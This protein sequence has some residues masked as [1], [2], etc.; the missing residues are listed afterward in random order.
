MKKLVFCVLTLACLSALATGLRADD[1]AIVANVD[2]D[3][4]AA[5]KTFPAGTYRFAPDSPGSGFVTIRNQE[6]DSTAVVLP[7]VYDSSAPKRAHLLLRR[8]D[9]VNYLSEIAT[10][11][12]VY[13]LASPRASK[14]EEAKEHAAMSSAGT[15]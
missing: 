2:Q 9:G 4:V 15:N 3:F 6:G 1:G 8:V 7:I 5:G 12:G 10:P 11:L 13:T 14:V